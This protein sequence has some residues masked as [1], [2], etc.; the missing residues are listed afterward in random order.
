MQGSICASGSYKDL[1]GKVDFNHLLEKDV[2]KTKLKEK[3]IANMLQETLSSYSS[4]TNQSRRE[5]E[6]T[7]SPDDEVNVMV[8]SLPIAYYVDGLIAATL[9]FQL[10][11]NHNVVL[12]S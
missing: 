5:A 12:P 2:T 10:D 3:E 8:S 9:L 1:E 7:S 6:H 11:T 4:K